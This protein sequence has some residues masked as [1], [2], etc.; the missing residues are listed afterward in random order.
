VDERNYPLA[1]GI[2]QLEEC[3]LAD[4]LVRKAPHASAAGAYSNSGAAANT[5][6]LTTARPSALRT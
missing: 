2:V 5:A 3:D 1:R 6:I 4:R